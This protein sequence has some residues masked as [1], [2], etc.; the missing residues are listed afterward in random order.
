MT[1]DREVVFEILAEGG[2]IHIE[3]QKTK[4]VEKFFYNHHEFD[5]T[6]KGLE[7]NKNGE[8][9]T[10]EVPFQLINS[11]FSWY[12]LHLET[13][14]E[15]YRDY[16]IT[17]LL[18]KLHQHGVNPKELE[19]SKPQ[20]E[21]V[22]NIHL[23]FGQKP[24]LNKLQNITVENLVQLTEYDYQEFSDSYAKEI[25]QKF[26]LKGTFE[27][28]IPSEQTFNYDQVKMSSGLVERFETVGKL[29]LNGNATIIKDEFDRIEYILPTDKFFISATPILSNS[30]GWF[31]K[32]K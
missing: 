11:Q 8:Y 14:S 9:K 26:K 6:D 31:Y 16:V 28:W 13:V 29:E 19:Y 30:K 1:K 23:E 12:M 5:Q 27:V 24:L 18:K 7:V 20:L 2:G 15:D 22:L 4:N 32:T 17:E 10:F 3:R 25:G 21:K